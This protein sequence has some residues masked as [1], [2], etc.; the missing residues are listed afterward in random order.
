LADLNRDGLA[1]IIV[2]APWE[3]VGSVL[4]AGAVTVI[5]GRRSGVLGTGAYSFNQ[6]TP[7]VPSSAEEYDSFG[8]TVSAADIDRDGRPELVVGSPI[9][10][11]ANG[12]VFVLPGGA[13]RPTGTGSRVFTPDMFG[14]TQRDSIHLGGYGVLWILLRDPEIDHGD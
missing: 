6:N 11:T 9:E 14:L 3:D 2:G 4:H 5:P 10:N 8:T 1:D 12:A 13:T 7:G